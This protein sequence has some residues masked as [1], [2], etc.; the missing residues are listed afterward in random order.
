E[1]TGKSTCHQGFNNLVTVGLPAGCCTNHGNGVGGKELGDR[2]GFSAVFA[3]FHHAAGAVG[4]VDV[5]VDHDQAVFKFA[6][7]LVARVGEDVEHFAVLG[8]DFGAEPV[9]TAFVSS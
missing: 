9:D 1:G 5:E 7:N 8:Q 3:G 6:G 4:G 2:F